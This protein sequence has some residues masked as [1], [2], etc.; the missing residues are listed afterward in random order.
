MDDADDA[1]LFRAALESLDPDLWPAKSYLARATWAVLS[2]API[3]DDLH[4]FQ[5][6]QS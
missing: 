3:A 1:A 6:A 4:T 2:R 5:S